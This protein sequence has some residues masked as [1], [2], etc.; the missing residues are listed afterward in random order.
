MLAP[1]LC[2]HL[3]QQ[4]LDL[5]LIGF[6]RQTIDGFAIGNLDKIPGQLDALLKPGDVRF[7]VG[8]KL[9]ADLDQ[10]AEV[11]GQRPARFIAVLGAMSHGFQADRLERGVDPGVELPWRLTAQ[12]AGVTIDDLQL[13]SDI[14]RF[15]VRGSFDPSLLLRTASAESNRPGP[16]A[17][18]PLSSM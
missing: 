6:G 14:G 17:N 1:Q 8:G 10:G 16:T 11:I 12:P 18:R 9:G 15:A 13:K 7:L 3:Q 2:L 5:Q 4:Y